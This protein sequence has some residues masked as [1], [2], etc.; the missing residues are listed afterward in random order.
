M[1]S[2]QEFLTEEKVLKQSR[3][4]AEARSL[5]QQAWDRS[6]DLS[7]LPV[8]ISNAQFRFESAYECLREAL[9]SF[10]SFEGYKAYSHEAIVIFS[11]E[12]KIL[13]EAQAVK[14]DRYRTIR[15]DINYRGKKITIEEA[16]EILHL[17]KSLLP[18]LRKIL[19]EKLSKK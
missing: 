12:K 15:N 6:N 8:D 14:I 3:D 11:L 5:M 10:L 17:V 2:F 1:K 4:L 9:Q 7:S 19:E 13:S 18:L 16:T